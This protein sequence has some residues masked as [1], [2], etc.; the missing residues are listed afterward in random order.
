M[1]SG[2][3]HVLRL[4]ERGDKVECQPTFGQRLRPLGGREGRIDNYRRQVESISRRE[5]AMKARRASRRL[6]N[7]AARQAEAERQ[8]RQAHRERAKQRLREKLAGT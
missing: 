4:L 5:N 7:P 6:N 8:Q 1:R 2:K 3:N